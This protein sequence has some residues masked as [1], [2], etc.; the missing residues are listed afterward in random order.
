MI[1]VLILPLVAGRPVNKPLIINQEHILQTRSSLPIVLLVWAVGCGLTEARPFRI[2]AVSNPAKV[3]DRLRS[4]GFM[5]G[6]SDDG[7]GDINQIVIPGIGP[8]MGKY[9]QRYGRGGQSAMRDQLHGDR[10]NPT[11]AGFSDQAGTECTIIKS[12]GRLTI[13]A[14]PCCLWDADGKYD[15]IQ[16]DNLVPIPYPR[17]DRHQDGLDD[18]HLPGKEAAEITSEFNFYGYY[19]NMKGVGGIDIPCIKHYFEYRFSRKPGHALAEFG[20]GT[21]IY[22]PKGKIAN[23]PVEHPAGA[24]P[25]HWFDLSKALC[26]WSLRG[27]KPL[28]NPRWVYYLKKDGSWDVRSCRAVSRTVV[29]GPHAAFQPLMILSNS[30]NPNKGPAMGIYRPDSRIN[31][32]PV[33]GRRDNGTEVYSDPRITRIIAMDIPNRTKGMWK[34]GFFMFFRGLL[35]RNETPPGVYESFRTE[36]YMLVGSPNQIRRAAKLIA[37]LP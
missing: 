6:V 4:G 5:I 14:H 13:V 1:H 29:Y 16:W 33:V 15:F 24:H 21:P 10:Y 8:I 36:V 28:W 18:S 27:D 23:I 17:A 22:N 32:R 34:F 30:K 25:A 2:A 11:Q 26:V 35:N 19:Q 9:S 31:I 12:P 7:G 20:P 37:R 3:T